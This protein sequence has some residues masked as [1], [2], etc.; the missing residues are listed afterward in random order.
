MGLVDDQHT[1]PAL[2]WLLKCL[3]CEIP[4]LGD[5]DKGSLGRVDT[6]IQMLTLGDAKAARAR[7]AGL[8]SR[9]VLA[10]ESFG[11]LDGE[12]AFTG[13]RGPGEQERVRE[14]ISLDG[15]PKGLAHACVAYQLAE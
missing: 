3:A 15:A 10:Q 6:H 12:S 4:H 7:V 14:S 1:P 9:R 5:L 2:E 8:D 11:K 13:V